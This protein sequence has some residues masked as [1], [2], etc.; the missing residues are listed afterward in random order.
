MRK[1]D[2]P[3]MYRFRGQRACV[4]FGLIIK[5]SRFVGTRECTDKI[6]TRRGSLR[7]HRRGDSLRNFPLESVCMYVTYAHRRWGPM[8]ISSMGWQYWP[9]DPL[10]CKLAHGYQY[11]LLSRPARS[12]G[13]R[14]ELYYSA[15][16][17]WC[18]IKLAFA[19]L[20]T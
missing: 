4:T 17:L 11:L 19:S 16:L 14:G 12:R 7:T 10:P 18:R 6:I 2:K 13:A 20:N 15:E 3:R 8:E 1:Q 9:F 5:L